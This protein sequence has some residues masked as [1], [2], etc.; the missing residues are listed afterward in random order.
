MAADFSHRLQ[1]LLGLVLLPASLPGQDLGL[2]RLPTIT[3]YEAH[4]ITSADPTGG[5]EDWRYLPFERHNDYYS[6]AYWYEAEPHARFPRLPSTEE[7]VNWAKER[8]SPK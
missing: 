6:V 4:R 2:D 3:Q 1:V 7:R 8:Q 5:N